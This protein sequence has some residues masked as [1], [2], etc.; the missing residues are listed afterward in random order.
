MLGGGGFAP[1]IAM[2]GSP[3]QTSADREAAREGAR[4]HEQQRQ[5]LIAEARQQREGASRQPAPAA[6]DH[7]NRPPSH[8]GGGGTSHRSSDE[9]VASR[10]AQQEARR[11]GLF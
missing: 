11:A 6:I 1:A 3:Q 4:L 8:R 5:R 2:R 7:R 9:A 10:L